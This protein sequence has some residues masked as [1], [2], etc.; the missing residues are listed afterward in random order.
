MS[1]LYASVRAT[2][3][4]GKAWTLW[5]ETR[6][7]LYRQHTMSP[8]PEEER[9]A[10][11]RIDVFEYDAALRF[12]IQTV[13]AYGPIEEIPVGDDGNFC[14]KPIARTVGLVDDLGGELT[15]YWV[16]AYGGGLFLPFKDKTNENLTYGGGRYL[17]DAIK[18]ADLGRTADQ[19]IVLDF[20]FAYHPSCAWDPQYICPLAPS[21]N[22]LSVPVIGGEYF[23]DH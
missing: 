17:I 9:Y 16:E 14:R 2:E 4:T 6:S 13:P 7:L 12:E 18:S 23:P 1:T 22:T 5:H 10:F 3:D 11:D 21:E 20:N 15:L 19:R 8:V